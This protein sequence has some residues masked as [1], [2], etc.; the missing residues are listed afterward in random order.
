VRQGG[1]R[2]EGARQLIAGE[3][4]AAVDEERLVAGEE[5]SGGGVLRGIE[6]LGRAGYPKPR[7]EAIV[8]AALTVLAAPDGD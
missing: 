1:A 6:S 4:L 2:L 3:E 7:L 8:D 5:E